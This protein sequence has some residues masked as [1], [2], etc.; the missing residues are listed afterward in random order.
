VKGHEMWDL[1]YLKLKSGDS[2][3]IIVF[4]EV[5]RPG[6]VR[7]TLTFQGKGKHV[8]ENTVCSRYLGAKILYYNK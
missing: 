5:D 1:S 6:D 4:V 7:Y 8:R 2:K 3:A